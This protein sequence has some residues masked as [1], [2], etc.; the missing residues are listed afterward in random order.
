MTKHIKMIYQKT[1][2]N[3]YSDVV[4]TKK[5]VFQQFVETT[6]RDLMKE[7]EMETLRTK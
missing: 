1:H 6:A 4:E 5:S 2:S 7:R 3:Y